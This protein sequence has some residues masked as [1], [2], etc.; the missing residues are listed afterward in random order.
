MEG[1]GL[2]AGIVVSGVE[3]QMSSE[4][5]LSLQAQALSTPHAGT[6]N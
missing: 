3:K 6:S 1:G 2:G 5:G 4:K